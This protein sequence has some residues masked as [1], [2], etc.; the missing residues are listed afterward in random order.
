MGSVRLVPCLTILINIFFVQKKGLTIIFFKLKKRKL[1]K[2]KLKKF[3]F[4][5][6]NKIEKKFFWRFGIGNRIKPSDTTWSHRV[7]V[8]PF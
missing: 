3:F 6:L 5:I 8:Y 7:F 2:N 1:K 4:F